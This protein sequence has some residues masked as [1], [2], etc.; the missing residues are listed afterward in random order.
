MI[1]INCSHQK[2][3]VVN[4]RTH[5][6]SAQIWRRRRCSACHCTFTTYERISSADELLV[7]DSSGKKTAFSPGKLIV[8]VLNCLNHSEE[9]AAQAFWLIETIENQLFK[10]SNLLVTD[11]DISSTTHQVLASFDKLAGE[12]YAVRHRKSL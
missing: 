2:T 1:C 7:Q 10:K 4:S 12:Q 5:K 9:K 6:S 11:K 3:G 8:S